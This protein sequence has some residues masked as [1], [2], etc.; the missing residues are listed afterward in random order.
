M[1]FM[2][3]HSIILRAANPDFEEGCLFARYLDRASEGFFHFWLG[4]NAV[5]I[6][7]KAYLQPD[8]DLSYQHVTFAEQDNLIEAMVSGYTAEQ[9]RR[10]S[11]RPLKQASGRL[12]LRMTVIAILFAPIFRIIDTIAD[13][14]FYLQAIAV[15]KEHCGKGIGTAL[16]DSIEVKAAESGATR[17][18]LDVSAKNWGARSLYEHR[19]WSVESQWPKRM[20][21]PGLR[22]I[23]MAKALN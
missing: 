13:G 19:G 3:H 18:V 1:A 6:L 12:H 15:A 11:D 21:I 7:A 22:I 4:R 5:D 9:H 16:M 20:T 23:R 10:S 14:D 17:I 2:N 8:H